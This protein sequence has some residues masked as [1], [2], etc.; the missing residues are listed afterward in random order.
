LRSDG[1]IYIPVK[2]RILICLNIYFFGLYFA[3][4]QGLSSFMMIEYILLGVYCYYFVY[5]H[6]LLRKYSKI[7]YP[8]LGA[9]LYQQ[10]DGL[11]DDVE[12]SNEM[13]FFLY[14]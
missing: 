12:R 9:A 7:L 5:S 10:M 1:Q 3:F 4:V 8:L 11:T 2:R 14:Q 13:V 6:E